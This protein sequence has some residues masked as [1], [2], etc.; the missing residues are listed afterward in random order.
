MA[1]MHELSLAILLAQD[2]SAISREDLNRRAE[3]FFA[4]AIT[5]LEQNHRCAQ[6]TVADMERLNSTLQQRTSELANSSHKVRAQIA[7]R[8][9]AETSLKQSQLTSSQLLKESRAIE[10]H[11][12]A[13]ARN[14]LSS[15]EAERKKMSKQLNDEIV[16]AL[17]SI[18]IL[19][20]TLKKQVTAHHA[21]ISREIATTQRLVEE[22][23]VII[24][25]LVH[26]F[27]PPP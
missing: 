19:M 4:E 7:M 14:T 9:V 5:P 18:K 27:S 6:Q 20:L 8:R 2:G 3:L 16:Q 1:R 13:M 12:Q 21:D 17:L 24:R 25:H 15:T 26:Q 23:A 10:K 11:L 22:S